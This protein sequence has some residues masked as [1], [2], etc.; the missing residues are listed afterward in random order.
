MK[1][2]ELEEVKYQNALERLNE[3]FDAPENSPEGKEADMLVDW[4]EQYEKKKYPI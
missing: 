1:F 4:I 2:D 3:I